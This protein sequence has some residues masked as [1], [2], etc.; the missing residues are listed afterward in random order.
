MPPEFSLTDTDFGDGL[1]L[2]RHRTASRVITYLV[3]Q[4]VMDGI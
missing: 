3:P 2:D 4:E 1:L